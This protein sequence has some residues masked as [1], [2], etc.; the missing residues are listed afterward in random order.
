[1]KR[2]KICR[3]AIKSQNMKMDV[4]Y[5]ALAQLVHDK[6]ILLFFL[7]IN[8]NCCQK[9]LARLSSAAGMS[10]FFPLP[11]SKVT[12]VRREHN[13]A[14]E[15]CKRATNNYPYLT[16]TNSSLTLMTIRQLQLGFLV[17]SLACSNLD[18]NN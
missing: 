7:H 12:S 15:R 5:M 13:F 6:A 11:I 1:M 17:L 9:S 18:L 8:I 16:R 10:S 4:Q 14:L 3:K 2:S